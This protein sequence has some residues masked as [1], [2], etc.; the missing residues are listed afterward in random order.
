MGLEENEAYYP[1]CYGMGG[2]GFGI[3][4]ECKGT[5]KVTKIKEEEYTRRSKEIDKYLLEQ[6]VRSYL[7]KNL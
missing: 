2:S 5:A 6:I 4:P 1:N 3:C 7:T